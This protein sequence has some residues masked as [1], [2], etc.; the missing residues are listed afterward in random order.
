MQ[1]ISSR[2]NRSFFA[3][4]L[5]W[6]SFPLSDNL[7]FAIK[8]SLSITLVY[9]IALSQ[10]WN[11]ASTAA[12][13]V[14]MI[15]SLGS[16]GDSVDK[17]VTRVVGTLFGGVIG[18]TLIAIFPQERMVYLVTVSILVA[19]LLYFARAFRGDNTFLFIAAMTIMI[20]FQDANAEDAFIYGIE[21]TY[22]TIFGIVV[23]TLVGL[24][25]WPVDM[26][27]QGRESAVSLSEVQNKFYQ[28]ILRK[29]REGVSQ[30]DQLFG[31]EY[32]LKSF[33]N[34]FSEMNLSRRQWS[35]MIYDYQ[36]IN[37]LL[38]LLARF[39]QEHSVKNPEE[40]IGSYRRLERE[41]GEMLNALPGAWRERGQID[42]PEPFTL[43]C[44]IDRLKTLPLS[45]SV[46]LTAMSK[47]MQR[48]HER[49]R[50][51]VA[52]LNS[53]NSTAP[54]SFEIEKMP[55][56][57]IFNW[58]DIED[59][60]GTLVSFLVFWA[61]V[62]FWI[63]FNPPGG[64]F[65][66]TMAT[67]LSMVTAFTPIKPSILIVLFSFSFLFAAAMYVLVLPQLHYGWE[68]ALFIFGYAFIGYYLI[69]PKVALF[70]LIGMA[71][72]NIANEMYY[73]FA[74]FLMGLF[75]FYLFLFILLFFYYIPF[76][77]RPEHLFETLRRR[78][79]ALS[80][81][82][83][84]HGSN[85]LGAGLR[86]KYAMIHLMNTAKKMEL[87]AGQI[88]T[89]YFS[90][91]QKEKLTT[92]VKACEEMA[93]LLRMMSQRESV[94]EGKRLLERFQKIDNSNYM[95]ALASEYAKGKLPEEKIKEERRGM[96][97]FAQKI[98]ER[99]SAFIAR[100]GEEEL[101]TREF[102]SFMESLSLR[103]SVALAFL[104]CQKQMESIPFHQLKESRF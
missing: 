27:E 92:F 34:S 63:Y 49:L 81:I 21:R 7:K 8:A 79:F 77:T 76:S 72:L 37:E 65:I 64:F 95:A 58:F 43:Q 41:T 3:D 94:T 56:Q 70:F 18:L 103:K 90:G 74:L 31:K 101:D 38:L 83:L 87:W 35:A 17:G 66:V 86:R 102:A 62:S 100:L 93:Y 98:Q 2:Q 44:N 45:D 88:D 54:T 22:M 89:N 97:Q 80:E 20:V 9:L 51:L 69:N 60:K 6:F 42:L 30:H 57:P 61:S 68:L 99:L 53:L 36:K 24:F 96:K 75:L 39:S 26:Q 12:M 47:E 13:T 25:L 32:T 50:R 82:L 29:N 55:R 1:S 59:L 71:T 48:L 23:Y 4:I 91:I 52:K 78:F 33:I 73:N 40:Y 46:T 28:D 10:G 5:D 84:R 85:S 19:L 104:E 11:H 16:L 14:M 67:A 15:A